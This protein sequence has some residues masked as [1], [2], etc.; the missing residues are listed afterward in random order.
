M[1]E[2]LES[3]DFRNLQPCALDFSPGLTLVCG[4]NGQGK[5]NLL[6]AIHLICQG[7]SFRTRNLTETVAWEAPSMVLRAQ[8]GPAGNPRA[9]A[10]QVVRGQGVKAKVDG[11]ESTG[12]GA[13][14]GEAPVVMMGP[15]DM[16]LVRGGPEERRRYLDELLCYR[17]PANADLLRRFRRVLLQ[18]NRW[19]KDNRE[20]RAT[21]GEEVFAVWTEQLVELAARLWHERLALSRELAPWIAAYHGLLSAGVDTVQVAYHSFFTD[22]VPDATDLEALYRARLHGQFQTERRLGSTLS[23]PH[24]DDLVLSMDNHVL[25]EV[26]SQGQCRCAALALRL[27]AVDL[28]LAHHLAPVLLLDDIFAELDPQRREAVADV[29]RDK[30][31]QTFVATPHAADLPF[32]GDAVWRVRGGGVVPES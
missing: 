2:R 29:I 16:E 15:G 9:R 1:I 20:N 28:T 8:V 14:F 4:A 23:G 25:R 5:S 19:L 6:E 12:A 7:F 18:R 17:K 22:T 24:R 21:G 26:G 30:K 10:L 32:T 31:C 13:L 27:A 11:Q 3:Q